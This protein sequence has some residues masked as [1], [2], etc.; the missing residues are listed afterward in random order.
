MT[1]AAPARHPGEEPPRT[2]V[3]QRL[4]DPVVAPCAVDVQVLPREP[5]LVES[6]LLHDPQAGRV[7]GPHGD[8]DAVQTHGV[9]EV[10]ELVDASYRLLA[11]RGALAELDARG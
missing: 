10:V 5:H 2:V 1:T 8:L 6:E 7:L 3:G 11:P 4:E 9:E